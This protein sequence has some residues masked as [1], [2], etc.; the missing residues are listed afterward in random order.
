MHQKVKI[1]RLECFWA[2]WKVQNEAIPTIPR[3]GQT[4]KWKALKPRFKAENVP[5]WAQISQESIWESGRRVADGAGDRVMECEMCT[6]HDKE[7]KG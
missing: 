4:E 2:L 3:Q 6:E 1:V 7:G 5:K